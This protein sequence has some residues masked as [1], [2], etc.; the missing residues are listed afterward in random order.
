MKPRKLNQA[1]GYYTPGFFKLYIA[2][3]DQISLQDLKYE[4]LVTFVHEYTHFLQDFTTL[5]GLENIY[6]IFEWLRLFVTDTTNE[7]KIEIPVPFRH[8]T[9]EAHTTII[10][11]AFGAPDDPSLEDISSLQNIRLDHGLPPEIIT[12]HPETATFRTVKAEA[13]T[14]EGTFDIEIGIL[15]ITES[16]SYLAEDLMGLPGIDS[17]DYPYNTA[18]LMADAMCPHIDLS[19]EVLFA[20]CDVALQCSAPGCA[21]YEMLY[22]IANGT[23]TVPANGYDVYTTFQGYFAPWFDTSA[24]SIVNQAKNHLINLV[25]PPM[26]EQYQAWIENIFRFAVH[27]RQNNPCFL[28][29]EFRRQR[30]YTDIVNAIGTPLMENAVD[31]FSK[32]PVRFNCQFPADMD[33]EFFPA[34]SYIMDLFAVGKRECPMREWCESSQIETDTKC[35]TNTPARSDISEYPGLCPVGAIWRSWNLSRYRLKTQILYRR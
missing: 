10:E 32:V 23:Y 33:V 9:I 18:R 19:N 29:D 31:E 5:S 4:E 14:P 22:G 3:L 12:D 25:N 24:D 35:I 1:A 28:I 6:N 17:P 11:A 34:L 15:G 27:H 26:G 16:M 7:R 21:M 8:E 30:Y 2:T 13:V 20:L